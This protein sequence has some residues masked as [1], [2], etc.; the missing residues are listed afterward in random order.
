MESNKIKAIYR[1]KLSSETIELI[2]NFSKLH[3]YSS[4]QI[5]QDKWKEWLIINK[6]DIDIE[7]D[8]LKKLGYTK[9]IESKM[10]TAARYY[11]KKKELTTTIENNSRET[12][13]NKETNTRG[14]ISLAENLI[15]KMDE[16]IKENNRELKPATGYE[17]FQDLHKELINSEVERL[18][19]IEIDKLNT[20]EKCKTKIKK[21]YKNR[22]Y[23][24][25]Q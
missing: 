1:Y 7:K 15:K 25:L 20:R 23:K 16:F 14:Y 8:R 18:I 3:M 17:I 10:Y 11:F 6:E 12:N 4:R 24:V 21:T 13:I 9:N 19:N 2:Q 5:F 22:C